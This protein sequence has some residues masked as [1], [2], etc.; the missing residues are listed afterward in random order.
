M[1]GKNNKGEKYPAILSLVEKNWIRQAFDDYFSKGKTILYF[2]TDS[3]CIK[4][5]GSL[6][7]KHVY[8]KLKGEISIS[9]K[10]DFVGFTER[11]PR[12]FR[13]PG[14]ENEIAKYYYGFK[15]PI[16]L[17]SPFALSDLKYFKSGKNLR[18]DVPGAC[19]IIDPFENVK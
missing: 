17:K 3:N 13:L 1:K 5:A 14:C 6:N 16:W 10:A 9:L 4:P 7:I 15:I 12:E 18:P 11:N 2:C 19:I 8:F